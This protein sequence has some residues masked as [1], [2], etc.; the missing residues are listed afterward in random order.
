MENYSFAKKTFRRVTSLIVALSLLCSLAV[1]CVSA[2]ETM[3]FDDSSVLTDTL[4]LV[5]ADSNEVLYSKNAD[6]KRP[7]ASVT[8]TMT[9]ILALENIETPDKYMIE[10]KQEHIADIMNE[11]AST[12]GFENCIG[13]SF[14]AL[15][16]IYGL[17]LPSG[18]EAAQI[19]AYEV[20]TSP[21][22]FAAMMNV[23]ADEL[24][25][26]NTY[27]KESHG[28][29]DENYT[30]AEDLVI[31]AEYAMKN[32]L[33]R[34]IVSTEYYQP[35]G[36][37]YPF[38][39]TNQ[40]IA[41]ENNR[42]LYNKYVT[43]I[44]TGFTSKAGR[45]LVSSAQKG[46]D[47]FICVAL[48]AENGAVNHAMKDTSAL[49]DWAF[50]NY[51]NNIYVDIEREY[52]SVEIGESI[53]IEA[54]ITKASADETSEI[55]WFSSDE[56]I[57]T[58]SQDGAVY[59]VSLGQAKITA[60]TSTGNIDTVRVSVGCYNGITVTSRDGDY[61]SGVKENINWNSVKNSGFDFAIIRAGWGSEDYPNQNDSQF[62]NNVNGAVDNELPFYLSFVA[63]AQSEDEAVAEAEYFIKEMKDYFPESGNDYLVSV[64]YN[65]TYDAFYYNSKEL[66]TKIA[67]T[68]AEKL[69]EHGYDTMVYANKSVLN[70]IDTD[71]LDNNNVGI[72][73]RY[74]PYVVDFSNPAQISGKTPDMWE[75]RSDGYFLPASQDGYST[76]CVSYV[77]PVPKSNVDG[78]KGILGDVNSDGEVNVMDATLIQKSVV[79]MITLTDDENIRADVN[80]DSKVNIKDATAI[81]KFVVK[82][83]TDYPIGEKII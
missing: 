72:Y 13:E 12:A 33:F 2:E 73:Y 10:I 9:C 54:T 74:Y 22:E 56:N 26:K 80:G 11:D 7:I 15:D 6:V 76:L 48:G 25:C 37:S 71:E 27:F 30:T 62:V 63:Y 44:K 64:L 65:M 39:N 81:K 47:E 8:K 23:K 32:P 34:E 60:K 70:N 75:Y 78:D 42:G 29:S 18:C 79:N 51:T 43:G 49:Y 21:D 61:T 55:S 53:E 77:K 45:C 52:A 83:E 41:E 36:F 58:V 59:G 16:I 57:V 68:F 82:L 66:N 1:V 14:S 28:L 31:I 40:L 5:D 46:D 4:L 35:D 20:G 19:L 3:S 17:M 67:L 38:F 69:K 50:E 24:G